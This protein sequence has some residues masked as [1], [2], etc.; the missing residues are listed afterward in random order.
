MTRLR[1]SFS[2][3]IPLCQVIRPSAC[4][5]SL[6]PISPSTPGLSTI[7]V[8][9]FIPY[10]RPVNHPCHQFHPL[11]P[12]CQPSLSS[13]SP[14]TPGLS[15]IHVTNFTPYTR[16]VNHP[17]HQLHSLHPACQP[18][19]S[20]TSPPTPSLSSIH[21]TNFTPYTQPPNHPP[22]SACRAVSQRNSL[23]IQS[24]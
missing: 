18:S 23:H 4:Q 14:P 1:G 16:P 3:Y 15:S 17:C 12:A 22:N 8:T 21:V 10:T 2:I 7:H 24:C 19:M 20:P 11:H 5:P 9:N 6:S 13:T